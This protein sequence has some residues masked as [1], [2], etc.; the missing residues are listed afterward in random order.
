MGTQ[1]VHVNDATTRARSWRDDLA[2]DYEITQA[3]LQFDLA[4]A[5]DC[6]EYL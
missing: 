5:N 1:T 6:E 4:L 2:A 3:R